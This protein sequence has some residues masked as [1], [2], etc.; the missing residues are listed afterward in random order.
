MSPQGIRTIMCIITNIYAE[1]DCTFYRTIY[2][3]VHIE[4]VGNDSCSCAFVIGM[5]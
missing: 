1:A 4:L 2:N 3:N 5:V